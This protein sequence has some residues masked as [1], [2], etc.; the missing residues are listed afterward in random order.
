MK[1]LSSVA[2]LSLS[3][4]PSLGSTIANTQPLSSQFKDAIARNRRIADYSN[5]TSR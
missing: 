4:S 3:L 2:M 1:I 5:I